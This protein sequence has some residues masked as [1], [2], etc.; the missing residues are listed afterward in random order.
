MPA[1]QPDNSGVSIG[2]PVFL[3]F[4]GSGTIKTSLQN[5][6]MFFDAEVDDDTLHCMLVDPRFGYGDVGN[7][8]EELGGEV[9]HRP[10][11]PP[12]P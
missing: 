5:F 9:Y 8:I 3:V 10:P 1:P 2:H 7:Y 6:G 12:A 11:E 4:S